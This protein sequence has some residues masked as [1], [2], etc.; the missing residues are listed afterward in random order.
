M[1][2]LYRKLRRKFQQPLM[3]LIYINPKGAW[4]TYPHDFKIQTTLEVISANLDNKALI[5]DMAKIKA[6]EIFHTA[7]N[8]HTDFDMMPTFFENTNLTS[9]VGGSI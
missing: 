6:N 1:L 4:S 8:G 3:T 5:N 9:N 2:K 7:D